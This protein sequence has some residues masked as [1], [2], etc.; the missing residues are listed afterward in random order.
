MRGLI[1][2]LLLAAASPAA[3]QEVS[4]TLA[5]EADGTRALTHEVTVP[6]PP[7]EVWQAIATA[8]GWRSWAVPLARAVPGSPNRFETAYDPA[9]AAGAPTTIE[10][11]WL[12]REA[13]RRAVFRTTRTPTGFPHAEAYLQVVSTFTLTP[14]GTGATRVRLTGAGYPAGT[15]GDSLIAFF[16]EGNRSSLEQLHARFATGP[17]DWPARLARPEGK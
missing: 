5:T 9:A 13:P 16:R 2:A 11:Q 6:A 8:E 3:A 14:A 4:V 12:A 17:I 10:Q 15:E 1:A 7:A